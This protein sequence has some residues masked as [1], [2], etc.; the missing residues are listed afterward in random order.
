LSGQSRNHRRLGASNGS[1]EIHDLGN[2]RRG[3]ERNAREHARRE[4]D[5]AQ[6]A[7]R[8][9]DVATEQRIEAFCE[10]GTRA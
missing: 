5:E 7:S 8:V 3:N 9:D 2:T 1:N 4:H 6:R 10:R